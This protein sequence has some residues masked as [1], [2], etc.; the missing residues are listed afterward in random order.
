MTFILFYVF[1]LTPINRL[2][3]FTVCVW[4]R[5]SNADVHTPSLRRYV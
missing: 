4:E 2:N 5:L 3:L 1:V